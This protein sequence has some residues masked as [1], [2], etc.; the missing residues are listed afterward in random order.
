MTE[1]I[2]PL[3][4]YLLAPQAVAK[5][6]QHADLVVD[7]VDA[8]GSARRLFDENLLH[9]GTNHAVDGHRVAGNELLPTVAVGLKPG[10]GLGDRLMRHVVR[11]KRQGTQQH[12]QHLPVVMTV[13]TAKHG[14]NAALIRRAFGMVLPDEGLQGLFVDDRKEHLADHP[15]WLFHGCLGKTEQDQ[16]LAM[17]LLKAADDLRDHLALCVDRYTVDDLNQ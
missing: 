15:V 14:V 8:L 6:L 1:T 9:L 13:G 17:H 16:V 4:P 5:R 2:G 12:G 11:A 7:A 3:D 10:Q